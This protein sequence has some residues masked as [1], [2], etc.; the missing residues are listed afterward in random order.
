MTA[1]MRESGVG[2][3]TATEKL[4]LVSGDTH[5]GPRMVEDLRPYCPP[6]YLEAFDEFSANRFVHVGRGQQMMFGGGDELNTQQGLGEEAMQRQLAR[7]ARTEGHYDMHARL[8]DYDR[9][10]VAC[11]FLLHGSQNGEPIPFRTA[12]FESMNTGDDPELSAVGYHIY[13]QWLADVC[14]IEPERHVGMAYLPLWD[15]AASVQEL[16]WAASV[17]LKAVNLPGPIAGIPEYSRPEW[18]PFWSAAEA[19]NM[20]LVSHGGQET[21]WQYYGPAGTILQ[22]IEGGGWMARRHI[23][24]MAYSGVFYRHPGL[25]VIITEISGNWFPQYLEEIDGPWGTS[26]GAEMRRQI[27]ELPSEGV[28]RCVFGAWWLCPHETQPAVAAGLEGNL[29]WGSDYPHLEGTWQFPDDDDDTTPRSHLHLR[30]G[31]GGLPDDIIRKLTSENAARAYNLD[32][33]AL[34]KVAA[35]INAPTLDQVRRPLPPDEIPDDNPGLGFP[36]RTN[37]SWS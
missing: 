35:R 29:I 11:G 31:M 21:S 6:K 3:S 9:D 28:R 5:I 22:M 30:Y 23:H 12:P 26:S 10:G 4:V 13:N 8:R 17:G 7:N 24:W 37:W 32:L 33:D 20:A 2:E 19:H 36:F 25:K 1:T 15:I 27:P 14:T 18:E 16:E 34:S